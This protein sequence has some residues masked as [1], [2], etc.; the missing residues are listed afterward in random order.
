[1]HAHGDLIALGLRLR[2]FLER[3]LE[4]VTGLDELPL[5]NRVVR[6]RGCVRDE[7]C[8][9]RSEDRAAGS[10]NEAYEL[11]GCS[12]S[13]LLRR[14]ARAVSIERRAATSATARTRKIGRASC[15]ER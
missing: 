2:D 3:E 11:H 10:A 6:A 5:T 12:V 9:R 15:R 1:M 8:E 13:M 4:A 14:V 7:Q